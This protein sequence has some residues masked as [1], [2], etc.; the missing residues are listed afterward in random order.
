MNY[1]ELFNRVVSLISTPAKAWSEISIETDGKK[2]LGEFVYPMIG[3]CG[4]SVF[5]GTFIGNK[6]WRHSPKA[7]DKF[8]FL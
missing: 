1:K 3:L 7:L 2:V 6:V 4:L 5:I 8:A